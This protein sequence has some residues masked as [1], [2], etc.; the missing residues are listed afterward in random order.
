[1]LDFHKK[2][3]HARVEIVSL[4]IYSGEQQLE[5]ERLT[6]GYRGGSPGN[7]TLNLRIKRSTAR[8]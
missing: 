8:D 2:I 7:R 3:R 5:K 4:A 6:W 1:M